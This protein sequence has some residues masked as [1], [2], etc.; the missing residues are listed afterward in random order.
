MRLVVAFPILAGLA[1]A[2]CG[3]DAEEAATGDGMSMDDVAGAMADAEMPVPG[4]Y[5]TSQE[6]IELN[7]PGVDE[8][9]LAMMRSAFAEGATEQTTY[10]L[11][12]E[13][14]ANGRENMLAGMAESDCSVETF[15]ISGGRING[16]MQCAGDAG[17]NGTVA[18]SGTMTS[19]SSD[20]EMTI[21]A[22]GMGMGEGTIRT[23]V[24]SERVGD[25]E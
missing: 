20:M 9:M 4:M 7:L 5:A 21:S 19:T 14:A 8:S 2:A 16:V 15:E 10:C 24:K 13:D 11:T 3:S 25:C 18:M 23:R 12:E 6:L 1:L 22:E 17:V